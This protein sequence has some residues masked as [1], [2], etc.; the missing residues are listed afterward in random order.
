MESLS[1]RT[2]LLTRQISVLALALFFVP[3]V[4][5]LRAC[6]FHFAAL[7]TELAF[8]VFPGEV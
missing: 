5:W 7:F 1:W 6:L 4:S 2:F 3:D 8:T